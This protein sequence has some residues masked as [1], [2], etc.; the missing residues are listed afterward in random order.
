MRAIP[1]IAMAML[2]I[3]TEA[4]RVGALLI[5]EAKIPLRQVSGRADHL[6]SI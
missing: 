1:V 3:V 2:P 5:L 4:Q 6:G